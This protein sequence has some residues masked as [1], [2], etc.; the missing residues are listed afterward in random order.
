[1]G[2]DS[3]RRRE[4]IDLA[5]RAEFLRDELIPDLDARIREAEEQAADE[6]ADDPDDDPEEL[7]DLRERLEKQATDCERV[8]EAL[9][10]DGEFVIQELMADET[11]LLQDDVAE[12]AVEI[13]QRT[14]SMDVVP[15]QGYHRNRALQLSITEYPDEMDT[16]HDREIGRRVVDLSYMP[17]VIADYLFDC[18]TA[19]NDAGSVDEVGNSL[20][21]YGVTSSGGD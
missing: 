19:L 3:I 9:G 18:V 7:R 5:A 20:S 16:I 15:K 12:Q 8:T 1:M 14:E 6:G 17:D 11:G 13:D 21:S 2:L 4:S 10:G